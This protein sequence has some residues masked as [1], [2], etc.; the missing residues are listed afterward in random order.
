[1]PNPG[2]FWADASYLSYIA[3]FMFGVG[4]STFNTQ[5]YSIIGNMYTG[6]PS[7]HACTVFQLYQNLGLP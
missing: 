2:P 3:A 1:M 7:V 6:E 5:I 4:D